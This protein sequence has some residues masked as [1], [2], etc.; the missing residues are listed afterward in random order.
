M[1]TF[2]ATTGNDGNGH[3]NCTNTTC[4][5]R[6]RSVDLGLE[7]GRTYEIA[8]FARRSPPDRVELPADAQRVRDQKSICM[9]RCGDGIA[10]RRRGV[11]LR[12]SF[13]EHVDGSVLRRE[14]N[15]GSLRRLHHDCKYG[16]Y[17]GD[18]MPDA[19]NG[20]ECD[21]GSRMNNVTYGNK[22]GCAPGC[23]FPHFCGD[24]SSTRPRAS[25]ATSAR[26]TARTGAPATR[27]ASLHRLP[28]ACL[29]R[30]ARAEASR[31]VLW[32]DAP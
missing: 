17:C 1:L 15:D 25:S 5:C 6:T 14:V 10:D 28:V 21:L 32:W 12:R 16:P 18:G 24:G 19:A 8:V 27:P 29:P 9:P 31:R 3:M 2:N 20:E 7:M 30:R 22:D 11:R 4:D 23:K 26:P 13:G